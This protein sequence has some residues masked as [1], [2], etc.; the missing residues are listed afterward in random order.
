M[1]L[2]FK[3][4]QAGKK[5]YALTRHGE[6]I[7]VGTRGECQRF[8]EIHNAKVLAEREEMRRIPRARPFPVRTYQVRVASGN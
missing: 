6:E 8:L 3:C 1:E 2:M 7:F 5:F 4:L